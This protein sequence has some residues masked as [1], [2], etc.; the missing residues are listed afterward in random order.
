MKEID[1]IQS[2]L[3]FSHHHHNHRHDCRHW[4]HRGEELEQQLKY[5]LNIY[6]CL[7]IRKTY[8]KN[9]N[10]FIRYKKILKKKK[11]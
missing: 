4:D 9:K 8:K 1:I 6:L 7:K 2:N 3:F 11:K 10:K 5:N